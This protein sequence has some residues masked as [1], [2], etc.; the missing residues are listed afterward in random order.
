MS[1]LKKAHKTIVRSLI[2]GSCQ[3]LLVG[4]LL[5][6]PLEVFAVNTEGTIG[7][8]LVGRLGKEVFFG[9]ADPTINGCAKHHP[10][11]QFGFLTSIPGGKEMLAAVLAA[12]VSGKTVEVVGTDICTDLDVPDGDIETVNYIIVR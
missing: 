3:T 11:F 5:L 9:M 2:E 10:N 4:A 6:I 12:K 7:K 1:H 8:V